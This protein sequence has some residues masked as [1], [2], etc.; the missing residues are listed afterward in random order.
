L[1]SG[2]GGSASLSLARTAKLLVEQGAVN[3]TEALRK[4]VPADRSMLIE[5]TAWGPAHRLAAPL[6]I[7]GAPLRW[8]YPAG[9]LGSHPAKWW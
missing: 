3:D 4:E 8:V 9:K 5:Y 6:E 7:A 2:R 1:N